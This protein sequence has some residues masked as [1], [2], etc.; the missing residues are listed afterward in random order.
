M[1]SALDYKPDLR[2]FAL[3]VGRSGDGKTVAADGFPGK[4]L[5]LDFDF[6]FRGVAN[7]GRLGLLELKNID[8][9]QFNPR[10]GWD[11]VD[12]RL[13]ALD[14]LRLSGGMFPYKTI[15]VN[16]ITSLTRLF[17]NASHKLQGGRKLGS[18][19][20]SGPADFN[21]EATATHQVFDFLRSWPCNIIATA[22]IID[23]YG[24]PEKEF[25]KDGNWIN[26]YE[27]NVVVG[28]K[29]SVRDNLGENIMSY[30]DDIYRFSRD[31]EKG[32][33]RYFV[34]FAASDLARNSYGI[35]PG[36][37]DITGKNFYQYFSELVAKQNQS[38]AVAK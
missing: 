3:F 25:D 38:L 15:T 9:E 20:I 8:Y 4:V 16:S 26:Q 2:I 24:K 36:K 5:D 14:M 32:E 33:I 35:K 22:H 37:H 13:T 21:F 19:R 1:P 23:K 10:G 29:L 28:E 12:Q 7:A 18:L 34:E 31:E 30:F 27:Q 11:P 6:R 17:V